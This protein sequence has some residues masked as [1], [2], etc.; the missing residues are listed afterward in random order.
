MIGQAY[1]EIEVAQD[2][3]HSASK[4]RLLVGGSLNGRRWADVRDF[5]RTC[6]VHSLLCWHHK[7]RVF[8]SYESSCINTPPEQLTIVKVLRVW[9]INRCTGWSR[10]LPRRR[11]TSSR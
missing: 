7:R 1:F 9:H 3:I 8:D 10:I 4:F 5:N 2:A 11:N 6:Y